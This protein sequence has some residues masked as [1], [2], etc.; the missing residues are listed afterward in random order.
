MGI[1]KYHQ[2]KHALFDEVNYHPETLRGLETLHYH[3]EHNLPVEKE[4]CFK[5][6]PELFYHEINR[7]DWEDRRRFERPKISFQRVDGDLLEVD[8]SQNQAANR[9][10]E[11]ER[12]FDKSM[13]MEMY[14]Y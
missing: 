3:V 5:V 10:N 2:L 13:R 1:I 12:L 7:L 8:V 4:L 9:M 6:I 11:L 14:L